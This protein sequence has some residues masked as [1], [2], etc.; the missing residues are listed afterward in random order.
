MVFQGSSTGTGLSYQWQYNDGV[1]GWLDADSGVDA[2][3]SGETT[4]TLTITGVPLG[5]DSYQYKLVVTGT[6]SSAETSVAT[7]TVNEKPVITSQP[8]APASV[9]EGAGVINL[10]VVATGTGISYQWQVD[11]GGG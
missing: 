10:S 11:D 3:Y 4:P 2:E 7:L 9:C 8:V 5:W 1:S 6:C